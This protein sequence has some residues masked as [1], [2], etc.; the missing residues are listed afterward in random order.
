MP[1]SL[2]GVPETSPSFHENDEVV[3]SRV[4][5]LH[6]AAM[7]GLWVEPVPCGMMEK[8]SL[9]DGPVD[10]REIPLSF[11]QLGDCFNRREFVEHTSID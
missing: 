8:I 7:T 10:D 4:E 3:F 1:K 2:D 9:E 5:G 6:F 11:N